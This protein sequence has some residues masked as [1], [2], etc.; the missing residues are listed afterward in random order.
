MGNAAGGAVQGL[1]MGCRQREGNVGSGRQSIGGEIR[2]LRRV[3]SP[4]MD[5]KVLESH[6][7]GHLLGPGAASGLRA[8]HLPVCV[9]H[10]AHS[11]CVDSCPSLW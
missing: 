2:P 5:E 9:L 6:F 4:F 11:A 7:G 3:G 8:L 1:R 10:G